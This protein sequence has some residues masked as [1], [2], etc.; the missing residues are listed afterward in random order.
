MS[1]GDDFSVFSVDPDILN[2]LD[3][4]LASGSADF[5]HLIQLAGLDRARDLENRNLSGLDFGQSDLRGVSL[6]GAD[7]SNSILDL[8]KVDPS[9]HLDAAQV[10][11]ALLPPSVDLERSRFR[12]YG[13]VLYCLPDSLCAGVTLAVRK[14]RDRI[15]LGATSVIPLPLEGVSSSSWSYV[16]AEVQRKDQLLAA[17]RGK[18]GVSVLLINERAQSIRIFN[19]WPGGHTSPLAFRFQSLDG[20]F[21]YIKFFI[22]NTIV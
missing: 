5:S 8:C 18:S 15:W 11:G 3:R 10:S 20:V 16:V 19:F 14:L 21:N 17:L 7:L 4:V 12:P 9:T 13:V 2:A 1:T 22:G 6:T